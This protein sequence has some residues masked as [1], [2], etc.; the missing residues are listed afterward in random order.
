VLEEDDLVETN[1][2]KDGTDKD[3]DRKKD[4]SDLDRYYRPSW[5]SVDG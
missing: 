1:G 4:A 3:R 5:A 2:V